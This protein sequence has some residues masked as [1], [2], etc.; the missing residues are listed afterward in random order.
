[1]VPAEPLKP[2]VKN[3]RESLKTLVQQELELLPETLKE[4]DTEKRLNILCKLIPYVLPKVE[5]V[6][7]DKGENPWD[8]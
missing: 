4:L 7:S 8:W 3:L 2:L 1:M 5:S 6:H